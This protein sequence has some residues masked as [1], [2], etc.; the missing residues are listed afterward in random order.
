MADGRL[1]AAVE[2]TLRRVVETQTA[3]QRDE[4]DSLRRELEALRESVGGVTKRRD[5]SRS[6][7]KKAKASVSP[8]P[9]P[10]PLSSSS[11]PASNETAGGEE[12]EPE[13]GRR[14]SGQA[15]T[16]G[17]GKA[18]ET[19]SVSPGGSTS[20]GSSSGLRLQPQHHPSYAVIQ[21]RRAQA[22]PGWPRLWPRVL[23]A[24][25]LPCRCLF[26]A[27]HAGNTSS[28]S[29]VLPLPCSP[30][31]SAQI[32][33]DAKVNS[34]LEALHRR[35]EADAARSSRDL[36][37]VNERLDQLAKRMV[38]VRRVCVGFFFFFFD[39]VAEMV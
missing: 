36:S 21:V 31:L 5:G 11:P 8:P 15:P 14:G 6:K 26:A 3:G 9:P 27:N 23:H 17:D 12:V 34:Q 4:I 30:P 24:P 20:E 32:S 39:G 1:P 37:H 29:L 33:D 10:P 13:G 28:L 35:V 7:K 25:F 19:Q 38:Q 2:D 22:G 16:S 18:D